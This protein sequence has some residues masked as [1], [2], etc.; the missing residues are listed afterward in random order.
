MKSK[1]ILM[2]LIFLSIKHNI[3]FKLLFIKFFAINFAN[4][5]Y[6]VNILVVFF[7]KMRIDQSGYLLPISHI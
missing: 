3:F 4:T 5:D 6:F 1:T 2:K 7:R